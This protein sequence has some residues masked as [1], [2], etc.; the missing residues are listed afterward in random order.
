MDFI[1]RVST[2]YGY[3]RPVLDVAVLAFLIYQAYRILVK[4]QAVQLIK[5]IFLVAAFYG[6]AFILQLSTMLW[7]LNLLAPG[8][9]IALAILFQPEFRKIFMRLGQG[10]WF[11]K[12]GGQGLTQLDAVVG[13][14]EILSSQ[15]RGALIVFPRKVGLKNIVDTGT[16]LQAEL[17]SAMIVTIF[18]HDTPLHDGA[19]VVQEGRILAAACLL[20]LSE[21]KDIRRSFGTRHRAALG[22]SEE[23][24]AVVLVVS[25]ESGAISLAYDSRLY[26]DLPP[27]ILR[28]KLDDLLSN[29]REVASGERQREAALED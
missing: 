3:V 23:A 6:A 20:P 24:D 18:G 7:I 5:G 25:E 9:I 27:Q 11:R 4:T 2:V 29:M 1:H 15:K 13:A 21:Q 28:R 14:A 26:Y 19:I 16:R 12:A 8:I 10:S 17:S 22:L